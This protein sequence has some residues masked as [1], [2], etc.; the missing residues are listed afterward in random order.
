M[1]GRTGD[2]E[3]S[4]ADMLAGNPVYASL[5]V[6][7]H[8]EAALAL[9]GYN[10]KFWPIADYVFSVRYGLQHG[11]AVTDRR[12]ARYRFSRNES[13]KP[14]TMALSVRRGFEFRHELI[15]RLGARAWRASV[16]DWT[17]GRQAWMDAFDWHLRASQF[18]WRG[19]LAELGI[20]LGDGGPR[21]VVKA[22]VKLGWLLATPRQRQP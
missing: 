15:A 14:T 12:L 3:V 10:E 22:L 7:M 13:L 2:Y 19:V 4:T 11:I 9:G 20:R 18:D 5:G 1:A 17:I 16:L 8:R 6:V 21:R